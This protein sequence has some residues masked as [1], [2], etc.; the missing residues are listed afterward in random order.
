MAALDAASAAPAGRPLLDV[1]CGTGGWLELYCKWF[2]NRAIVGMDVSRD[3]VAE[4]GAACIHLP[5]PPRLVVAKA[6]DLP[7]RAGCFGVITCKVVVPYVWVRRTLEEFR[8]ALDPSGVAIVQIH[9]AL[10]YVKMALTALRELSLRHLAYAAWV[11]GNSVALQALGRQ[12]AIFPVGSK[13]T[14]HVFLSRSL[15]GRIARDCGLLPSH[16]RYPTE[17]SR[18][19][20][21]L[22]SAAPSAP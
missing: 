21:V 17:R 9:A 22:R 10:H 5:N 11:L 8:R 12:I 7:F 19:I 13:S 18:P 6:E 16:A 15:I 4:A 14:P 3:R 20:V 1:G 2:P